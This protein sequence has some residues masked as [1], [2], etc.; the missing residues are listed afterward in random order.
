[1]KET[2]EGMA[3]MLNAI[4]YK[5]NHQHLCGDLRVIEVLLGLRT[6]LPCIPISFAYEQMSNGI[7]AC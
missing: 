3:D 4:R 6:D 7:P 5:E 1:M 2:D